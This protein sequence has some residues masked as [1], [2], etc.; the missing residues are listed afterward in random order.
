LKDRI[1]LSNLKKFEKE[2]YYKETD[3]H[4]GDLVYYTNRDNSI[5]IAVVVQNET[6][7]VGQISFKG[8]KSDATKFQCANY[9]N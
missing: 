1:K 5:R 3:N 4:G 6:E 7:Y 8:T 2:K 9:K